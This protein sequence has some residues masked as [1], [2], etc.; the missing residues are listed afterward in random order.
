MLQLQPVSEK[1]DLIKLHAAT[2][3]SMTQFINGHQCPKL[4]HLIVQQFS[5]LVSH[6]ELEQVSASREM[7]QQL[8]EHWQK[9]TTYLL[10][11][12]AVRELPSKRH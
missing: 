6:P 7:Y 1:V 11:Q 2:C 12:H 8:L 5:L 3:F 4:A 9:V 10:E